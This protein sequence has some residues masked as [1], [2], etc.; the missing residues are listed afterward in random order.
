MLG[1]C[2]SVYE[3]DQSGAERELRRAVE[4]NPDYAFAHIWRG[5]VLSD[6][7][8]P[9]EALAELDRARELGPT[10]LMVSD[11]RGWALYMARKYDEAIAQIHKTIELEP[12]FAHA[13]CWLGKVYLQKGMLRAGLAE[14]EAAAR[15]PGGDSKLYAPWLGYAYALSGKRGDAFKIIETLTAQDQKGFASPFGVAAIY[16]GLGQRDQALAWLENAYQ[17]RDPLMADLSIEPAFDP[18]RSDARF[19]D[20]VRRTLS[21][22][23]PRGERVADRART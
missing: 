21:P 11:Q 9:K 16:C 23:E 7:G 10:S 13:H 5:E 2:K 17:A 18:L 19:Q 8:R 20:L 4:L 14:L 3:W 15:L 6:M 12:R 22:Y 1:F